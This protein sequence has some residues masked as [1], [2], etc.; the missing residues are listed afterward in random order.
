MGCIEF[1][2][3]EAFW[4]WALSEELFELV[5]DG[6]QIKKMKERSVSLWAL[7]G[8]YSAVVLDNIYVFDE[9]VHRCKS[10]T[11]SDDVSSKCLGVFVR[12]DVQS[13]FREHIP[14]APVGPEETD[15]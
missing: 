8:S 1:R 4:D 13:L 9:L 7:Q 2:T 12:L 6:G 11:P 5:L 14:P 15:K 3:V 10:R